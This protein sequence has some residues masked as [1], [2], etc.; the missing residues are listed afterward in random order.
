MTTRKW[1]AVPEERLKA[2]A[3]DAT[4][5]HAKEMLQARPRLAESEA[6][7]MFEAVISA[8]PYEHMCERFAQDE[9]RYAWPGQYKRNETQIAWNVCLDV[10]RDLGVLD[11]PE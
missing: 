6:R 1:V 7:E 2:W 11:K 4:A 10:L 8:P 9:A 5:W 3:S